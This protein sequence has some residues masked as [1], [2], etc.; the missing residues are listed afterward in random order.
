MITVPTAPIQLQ[1]S[2]AAV[3]PLFAVWVDIYWG[4]PETWEMNT[5]PKPLS[6]ALDEAARLRR[7]G[8][9]AKILPEGQTPR[10]DGLFTSPD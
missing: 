5:L 4:S 2:R 10:L 3:P 9:V 6:W 1:E 7:D 8:W